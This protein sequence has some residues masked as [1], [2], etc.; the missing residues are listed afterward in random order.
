MSGL[1]EAV[2]DLVA[3]LNTVTD[4]TAQ[5]AANDPRNH[6]D[7]VL[8]AKWPDDTVILAVAYPKDAVT[9]LQTGNVVRFF[10]QVEISVYILDDTES[11]RSDTLFDAIDAIVTVLK[12]PDMGS[13]TLSKSEAIEE[14]Q[15]PLAGS[16]IFVTLNYCGG[17]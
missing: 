7:S 6:W 5:A 17:N 13:T 4:V 14:I 12:G 9:K 3:K 15:Q 1:K 16:R 8:L 10:H 2:N 11:T